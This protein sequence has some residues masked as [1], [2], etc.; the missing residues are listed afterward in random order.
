MR[1]GVVRRGVREKSE[2]IKEEDTGRREGEGGWSDRE[3]K[4]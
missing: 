1:G 4:E 2:T 3:M